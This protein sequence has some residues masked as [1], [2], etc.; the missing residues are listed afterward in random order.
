MT[1]L[2]SKSAPQRCGWAFDVINFSSQV[3][4]LIKPRVIIN[5]KINVRL[6]KL[7][8]TE[9]ETETSALPSCVAVQGPKVMVLTVHYEQLGM[10]QR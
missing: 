9:T 3:V 8:T 7:S 1:V 10:L 4:N 5:M 6:V 2:A